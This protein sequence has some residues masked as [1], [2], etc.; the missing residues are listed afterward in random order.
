MPRS[1]RGQKLVRAIDQALSR[2]TRVMG[3]VALSKN[4]ATRSQILRLGPGGIKLHARA[5]GIESNL[6]RAV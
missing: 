2:L 5:R 4:R 3:L 1:D 6:T